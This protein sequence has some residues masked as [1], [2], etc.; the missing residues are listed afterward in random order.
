MN[1]HAGVAERLDG[2]GVICGVD[3]GAGDEYYRGLARRCCHDVLAGSNRL[4]IV[5]LC[6]WAALIS[7]C[8]DVC[9]ISGLAGNRDK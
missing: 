9:G 3:E 6:C 8:A 5:L 2:G 7:D 1:G 4:R